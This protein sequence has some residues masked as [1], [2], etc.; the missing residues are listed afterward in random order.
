MFGSEEHTGTVFEK[1]KEAQDLH[2]REAQS[3]TR[4]ECEDRYEDTMLGRHSYAKHVKLKHAAPTKAGLPCNLPGCQS[5]FNPDLA[6]FGHH[7]DMHFQ[8]TTGK[9]VSDV[10]SGKTRNFEKD[11]PALDQ[12]RNLIISYI[13]ILISILQ[14]LRHVRSFQYAF[15]PQIENP[16]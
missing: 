5:Q 8:N 3:G 16:T 6:A 14:C 10:C 15:K 9:S 11:S 4:Q 2:K 1:L 7:F 13:R 12:L